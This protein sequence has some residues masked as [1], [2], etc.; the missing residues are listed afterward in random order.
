MKVRYETAYASFE[1]KAKICKTCPREREDGA[2]E[3]VGAAKA[4]Q[5]NWIEAWEN[6]HVIF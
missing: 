6:N 1:S 2:R 5:R 4:N 3:R